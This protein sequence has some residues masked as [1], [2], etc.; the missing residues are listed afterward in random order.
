MEGIKFSPDGRSFLAVT[1]R[2]LLESNEIECA[3]WLFDSAATKSFLESPSRSPG[4][5]PRPLVRIATAANGDPISNVR[6][7]VDGQSLAFL[8][9]NRN[10]ERHLFVMSLTNGEPKQLSANG[11]DVTDFDR[12]GDTFVYTVVPPVPDSELYQ[13]AGTLLPDVQVGTGLSLFSLLYPKWEKSTFGVQSQQVWEVRSGK[14]SPVVGAGSSVPVSLISRWFLS[15]LSLSPSGRYVVATNYVDHV[16]REWESYQSAYTSS[17]TK[18]EA[19]NP[20]IAP[21]INFMRPEQYVLIDLY[22]GQMS[23]L[24]AAPLGWSGGYPD[25]IK[26]A[27]SLDEERVAVSNT[28]LPLDEVRAGAHSP[29]TRPCVAV[30]EITTRKVECITESH[31]FDANKFLSTP[32]LSSIEW[33]A[34]DQQLLLWYVT[35]NGKGNPPPGLFQREEGAWRAVDKPGPKKLERRTLSNGDLSIA[36]HQSLNEPPVLTATDVATGKSKKIWDP[37]PQLAKINLGEAT[38]YHWHDKAGHEWTGGLIKPPDYAPGHPYPLVIQ[39]HGFN[40]K[41]FLTDGIYPTANAGRA[42]AAHGIVV[43]QIGE[44][45]DAFSTPEEAEVDG[46]AGYQSAI[47]QLAA[48]GIVDPHRVGIIGFSRAGWYVLDSL[49][50]APKSFVAATLAESTSE[51]FFEYLINADYMGPQRAKGIADGIGSEPFGEGL[52]KWLID[53]PGF[54]TDKICAPILFEENNPVA[55]IYSWDIYAALRSQG[56]P[57]ELLYIRNGEHV[58]TKPLERFMSQ[59]MNVDWF[60]FWLNGR[61]DPDPLK[62]AQYARWRE[63]RSAQKNNQERHSYP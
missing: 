32:V 4:P 30:V 53:S 46:R 29:V 6:W 5:V 13:S 1:K 35:N 42:L 21:T 37:N 16:P 22:G 47:E 40:P 7:A 27:W 23:S 56:K 24:V 8:A 57:V 12:V 36:V 62:A 48:D 34:R 41:E 49:I 15:L 55:L 11:Q 10:S 38:V 14:A 9:R 28:F 3:L 59:E 19:D 26:A 2:G 58:L 50:H 44:I 17:F 52:K 51:S 18:I 43:L 20:N 54:N 60:D 33:Q 45:S 25:A 39:T 31:P 63:L 61:E